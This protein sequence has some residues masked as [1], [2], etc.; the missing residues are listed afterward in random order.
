MPFP[1]ITD[2]PLTDRERLVVARCVHVAR[3]LFSLAETASQDE[4]DELTVLKARM[5]G[6][7]LKLAVETGDIAA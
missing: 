4:L 5:L 2:V 6:P 7:D 1:Q 3:E